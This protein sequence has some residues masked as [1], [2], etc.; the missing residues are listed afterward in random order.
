M[1]TIATSTEEVK[2]QFSPTLSKPTPPQPK[3]R[4]AA[5]V[6]Y[7]NVQWHQ[8][9]LPD[10][11]LILPVCSTCTQPITDLT[12]GIAVADFPFE[13][14]W[15]PAGTIGSYGQYGNRPLKEVPGQLYFFH[16]GECD[17]LNGLYN[18]ELDKIFKS[19]QRYDSQR[20]LEEDDD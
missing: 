16:K 15:K 11:L 19:D 13:Q 14:A 5:Q 20:Q 8:L 1:N 17:R 3:L 4:P 12:M 2:R 10:E 7:F 6:S 9:G 18:I